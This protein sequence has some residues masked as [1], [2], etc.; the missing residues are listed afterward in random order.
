MKSSSS[1]ARGPAA[2][3]KGS[4]LGKASAPSHS[5]ARAM[6]AAGVGKSDSRCPAADDA[7]AKGARD[8]PFTLT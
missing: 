2:A 8:A 3:R 5:A 6:L 7:E 1:S 4:S